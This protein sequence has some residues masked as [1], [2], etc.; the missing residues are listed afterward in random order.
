VAFLALQLVSGDKRRTH[1][2][3][4]APLQGLS[5]FWHQGPCYK[6]ES[7]GDI[8]VEPTEP[9]CLALRLP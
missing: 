4:A 6:P 8:H 1:D 7:F 2:L 9:D 5:A 3:N